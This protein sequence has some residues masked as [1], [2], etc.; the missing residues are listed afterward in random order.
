MVSYKQRKNKT[1]FQSLSPLLLEVWRGAKM[2]INQ[3]LCIFIFSYE[4]TLPLTDGRGAGGEGK[5]LS[6]SGFSVK[7]TPMK[8]LSCTPTNIQIILL[9]S[10]KL[11][12]H[13]RCDQTKILSTYMKDM[14]NVGCIAAAILVRTSL[15]WI[16]VTDAL[17]R[18]A[19]V[20]SCYMYV[21]SSGCF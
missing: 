21:Y 9:R 20:L 10:P 15:L 3:D 16:A 18:F 4:T 11:Q 7:L 13:S 12:P 2:M 8:V 14:Q 1:G 19:N 6:P 17:L 5:T